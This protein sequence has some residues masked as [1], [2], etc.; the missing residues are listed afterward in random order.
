MMGAKVRQTAYLVGTIATAVITLLSLWNGLS[1]E[2]AT[3]LSNGLTAILG[4]LGVG[5]TA[6]AGTVLS[7][8]RK[9][10]VLDKPDLSPAEQ[11]INGIQETLAQAQVV[12]ADIERIKDA[13]SGALGSI[14]VLGPLAQQVIDSVNLPSS[15]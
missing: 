1:G 9:D 10:G 8:Q 5:A 12:A 6:T 2:A 7:K 11:A 4:L 15:K 14:P 13:A 3:A